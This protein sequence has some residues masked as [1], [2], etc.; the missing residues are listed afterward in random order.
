MRSLL[1][2]GN[3]GDIREN[4]VAQ[5]FC[6]WTDFTSTSTPVNMS[7]PAKSTATGF[8]GIGLVGLADDLGVKLNNGPL[9]K[10]WHD[11]GHAIS[12]FSLEASHDWSTLGMSWQQQHQ[13][14]Y[15]K[16]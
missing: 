5:L 4:T 6:D 15:N 11:T 7:T 9:D 10:A 13:V 12:L 16:I 3:W 2:S 14:I 8:V 1:C